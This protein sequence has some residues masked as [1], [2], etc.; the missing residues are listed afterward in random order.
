MNSTSTTETWTDNY[1]LK[2]EETRR[3][4]RAWCVAYKTAE[5]VHVP[6][7]LSRW[8]D[9]TKDLKLIP[10]IL[11]E[12][13]RYQIFYIFILRK[14][15]KLFIQFTTFFINFSD[16]YSDIFRHTTWFKSPYRPTGH[17]KPLIPQSSMKIFQGQPNDFL[18]PK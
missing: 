11:L 3:V 10:Q 4:V 6:E 14:I 8:F 1:L 2:N 12:Y 13:C 16:Y 15:I 17:L 9:D 5:T 7:V 18:D